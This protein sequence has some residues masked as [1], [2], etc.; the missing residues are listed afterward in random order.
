MMH[1]HTYIKKVLYVVSNIFPT[2]SHT[3]V[4]QLLIDSPEGNGR[5]ASCSHVVSNFVIRK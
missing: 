5:E 4:Y 3:Y 1:G 2:I